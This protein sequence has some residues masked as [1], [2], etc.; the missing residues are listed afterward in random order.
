MPK[1]LPPQPT[2][3]VPLSLVDGAIIT[4]ALSFMHAVLHHN[5]AAANEALKAVRVNIHSAGG[6]EIIHE[7]QSRIAKLVR[8]LPTD[9]EVVDLALDRD[10]LVPLD[11][12]E[13]RRASHLN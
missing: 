13:R 6:C 2:A 12:Y 9:C 1:P 8:Q 5:Q 3:D 4:T 10:K 11:V 7:L